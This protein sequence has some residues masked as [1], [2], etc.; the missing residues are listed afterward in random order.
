MDYDKQLLD[1]CVLFTFQSFHKLILQGE[2]MV[3]AW[4]DMPYNQAVYELVDKLGSLV[5]RLVINPFEES[6]CATFASLNTN[7]ITW[8]IAS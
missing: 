4:F 6:S 3:L 5:V 2:K 8:E 1:M 7:T